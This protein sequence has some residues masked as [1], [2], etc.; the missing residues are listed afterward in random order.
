LEGLGDLKK[1]RPN[2]PT[3]LIEGSAYPTMEAAAVAADGGATTTAKP[4]AGSAPSTREA[5]VARL[6]GLY[7]EGLRRLAPE[8]VTRVAVEAGEPG[9]G[10]E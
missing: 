10:T 1:G 8:A 3:M 9:A 7:E 4:S 5:H 2:A 6:V